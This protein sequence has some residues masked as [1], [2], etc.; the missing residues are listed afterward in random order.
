MITQ[1]LFYYYTF[2]GRK[3]KS[4]VF[5]TGMNEYYS[6]V[7]P[8][9]NGSIVPVEQFHTEIMKLI[10]SS[11]PIMIG[12]FGATEL[13]STAVFDFNIF[14]KYNA[15]LKQMREYSGF[16]PSEISYAKKFADLMHASMREADVM[17][18]WNLDMEEYYIKKYMHKDMKMSRLRALEP[19][20]SDVPWTLSLKGKKV[21]VIHPFAE[22]IKQ[23]YGRREFL[24]EDENILPE[25]ELYTLKAVQTIAGQKDDRFQTW[26]E[27]LDYMEKEALKI[28]F[29]VALI[30][31]GA[32]GYP[33]A[34]RLKQAGKKAIHMGGVLQILFGI[35]GG[36][37]EQDDMVSKLYNDYWVRPLET[38]RPKNFEVVENG[39]YW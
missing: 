11:E 8:Y 25:F 10:E 37:W 32:Y 7:R 9:G 29:D 6:K 27:A 39:C 36:R 15:V 5:K 26:F 34:A 35:R 28:D 17:A 30:G 1:F 22:S 16:F 13:L 23:Q 31:C 2:L 24:F 18:V 3:K 4:E 12:R 33:L 14:W 20:F 21:L 38:E 19:W